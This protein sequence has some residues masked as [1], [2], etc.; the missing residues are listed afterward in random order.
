[1]SKCNG[2]DQPI[3]LLINLTE[4]HSTRCFQKVCGQ[5]EQAPLYEGKLGQTGSMTR[6][7]EESNTTLFIPWKGPMVGV[8][9]GRGQCSE[10]APRMW[11]GEN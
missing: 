6:L 8:G 7:G 5:R 4:G 9:V 11:E 10:P 2:G 1:M 3:S